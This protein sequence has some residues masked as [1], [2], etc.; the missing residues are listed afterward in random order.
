MHNNNNQIMINED[1]SESEESEQGEQEFKHY[2]PST[3]PKMKY[4]ASLMLHGFLDSSKRAKEILD[5]RDL[6][7]CNT[8]SYYREYTAKMGGFNLFD[9]V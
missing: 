1:Y 4:L 7:G 2:R 9:A 6:Y 8:N 5:G 3:N